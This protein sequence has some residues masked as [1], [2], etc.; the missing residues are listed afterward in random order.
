MKHTIEDALEILSGLVRRS[1][2]IQINP[3][4][5]SLIRSLGKQVNRGTGLTDRQ[6]DLALKKIEKYRPGL[7]KN[8]VDVD[9][10][11]STT[12]LKF[13]MRQI[14]RS[15]KI[16]F[17]VSSSKKTKISIKYVFSKKFASIWQD[18]ESELIGTVEDSKGLKEVPFNEKNLYSIVSAL[19]EMN[20]EVSN[21]VQEVY[22]NIEQMMKD[23]PDHHPYIDFV[24]NQIELK[25]VSPHCLDYLKKEF[26]TYRDEDFLVFLERS[27]NCGIFLKNQEILRKIDEKTSDSLIKNI[28]VQTTSRF[29]LNPAEY[30]IDTIFGI[31]NELRQWPVLIFVDDKKETVTQIKSFVSELTKY[32]SNDEITVFFRLENDNPESKEFNQFVRENG[33]NNYI[34]PKTKAV[35]IVKTRIPKPLLNADWKPH[36]ALVACGYEYGRTSAYISDFLT[37]YYY[38]NNLNTN[39]TRKKGKTIIAQL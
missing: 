26:P 34:G 3:N 25:N 14:D 17:S 22:E 37:V 5:S 16:S 20:F 31:M 29:R 36:T 9:H 38:N 21:E 7:E 27:K 10:L 23:L 13:P 33:L 30:G 28:L 6:L 15:Q 4:E 1:V 19:K 39:Y 18:V 24:N 11:L 8:L 12:P 2:N 35:F 32:M